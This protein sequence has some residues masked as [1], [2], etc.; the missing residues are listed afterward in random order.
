MSWGILIAA[1]ILALLYLW[2]ASIVRKR[3]AV[4]EALAGVDVQLQQR[5]DLIPNVL[6][7]AKRFMEHEIELLQSI[8]SLR[9]KA[10]GLKGGDAAT[11]AKR[12]ET[13]GALAAQMDR[14]FA[15]AE[16]YPALKS[17]GPMMEAQR[18]YGEVEANL[19]AARRFYN[20]AVGDLRNAVQIFPGNLLAGLAGVSEL[21]PFYEASEAA[22][23][24]V[25]AADLLRKA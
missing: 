12:F 7:I 5:H 8:T 11:V 19:A 16:N 18:T 6:A 10:E 21:P 15:V 4:S 23:Q 25:N 1:A 2:Y 3:N 13:E 14:F 9:T 24:P 17:D 22:R 20:S